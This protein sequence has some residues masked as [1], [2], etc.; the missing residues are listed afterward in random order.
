MKEGCDCVSHPLI[1]IERCGLVGNTED[2]LDSLLNSINNSNMA[3]KSPKTDDAFEDADEAFRR[4][5]REQEYKREQRRKKAEEQRRENEFLREFEGEL[6]QEDTDDFLQQFEL[7][8]EA[9]KGDDLDR[10]AVDD[11]DFFENLEGIVSG[12]SGEK[13]TETDVEQAEADREPSI[14]A[15]EL[16]EGTL[17]NSETGAG[18]EAPLFEEL[19][20]GGEDGQQPEFASEELM[21]EGENG[22]DDLLNLLSG[23]DDDGELSEIGDL[24]KADEENMELEGSSLGDLMVDTIDGDGF[25][26]IMQEEAKPSGNEAG[27]KKGK[28]KK[29]KEKKGF[30][31]KLSSALFGEDESQEST[32]N[33]VVPEAEDLEN[34]SEENLQILKELEAAEQENASKEAEGKKGRKK[35]KDKKEKKEKKPKEKKERKKREKKV[36]EPKPPKEVDNT[37]PLPRVPVILIFLMAFSILLLVLLTIKGTGRSSYIDTAKQAMETGDYVKAYGELSGL[38]LKDS[39]QDLYEKV[40]AMALVQEQY[41]AYL[42]MMSEN[43]YSMALDALI[44]G[45]GRCDS[46]LATAQKY[47][48]ESEMNKLKTQLTEA[49]DNQFG[50]T[51]EEAKELYSIRDRED[52]SRQIEKKISA[53]NLE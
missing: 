24:L 35:K 48:L 12:A 31:A 3:G 47:G 28:K 9:E 38:E 20:E 41:N 43:K 15:G 13:K 4:F 17:E 14:P 44:R 1:S 25:T 39:E 50:M 22:D 40:E 42:V 34:I 30:F 49:L 52:Y 33:I 51:E 32:E 5:E 21:P 19:L 6:Y 18:E 16:S 11:E 37:P 46:N 23:L 29:K 45:I 10:G 53:M 2:Y 27:E 7:E 36:K 26:G 8:L